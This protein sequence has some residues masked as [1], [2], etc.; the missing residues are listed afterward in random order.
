MVL[1]RPNKVSE[2]LKEAVTYTNCRISWMT[3]FSWPPGRYPYLETKYRLRNVVAEAYEAKPKS[4][5]AYETSWL[6][7]S[8]LRTQ[9]KKQPTKSCTSLW[10]QG[11]LGIIYLQKPLYWR[12]EEKIHPEIDHLVPSESRYPNV[13][14][15]TQFCSVY[16]YHLGTHPTSHCCIFDLNS[17]SFCHPESK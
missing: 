17:E 2:A 3:L 8:S 9:E 12:S 10:S 11:N 16:Q 1:E 14:T 4:I 7:W 15:S 13:G 6:L 5:I